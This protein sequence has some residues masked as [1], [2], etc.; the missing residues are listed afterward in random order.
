MNINNILFDFTMVYVGIYMSKFAQIQAC[1]I[2]SMIKSN[3]LIWYYIIFLNVLQICIFQSV[4]K[5]SISFMNIFN[6]CA[7]NSK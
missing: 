3:D 4:E 2:V 1:P 7:N 6:W 5:N